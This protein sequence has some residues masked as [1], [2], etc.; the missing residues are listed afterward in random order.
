MLIPHGRHMDAGPDHRPVLA[1]VPLDQLIAVDAPGE[2]VGQGAAAG[3]SVGFMR[4]IERRGLRQ[5]A[6][7][8]A[9]QPVERR[10]ALQRSAFFVDEHH[11]DRGIVEYGPHARLALRRGALGGNSVADIAGDDLHGRT[12]AEDHRLG[13]HLDIELGPVAAKVTLSRRLDGATFLQDHGHP[14]ADGVSLGRGDEVPHAK[15]QQ[16]R[17]IAAAVETGRSAVGEHDATVLVD[18][19]GLREQVEK[20][21]VASLSLGKC[22]RRAFAARRFRSRGH[23]E[24]DRFCR[25]DELRRPGD[26]GFAAVLANPLRE[27]RDPALL[28]RNQALQG[29]LGLDAEPGPKPHE[30]QE[31]PAGYL[32]ERNS[33]AFLAAAVPQQQGAIGPR[34][35]DQ[36]IDGINDRPERCDVSGRQ[37]RRGIVDAGRPGRR[38]GP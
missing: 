38:G 16:I 10:V 35:D 26:A 8:V 14:L 31:R 24:R 11:S 6:L 7:F 34:H 29:H 5:F 33:R 30:I 13:R 21:L 37:A 28:T 3:L 12:A 36:R 22:P 32:G 15:P 1:D 2:Q 23:D 4:V 27:E 17:R 25:C 18:C 19:D 20:G 9:E